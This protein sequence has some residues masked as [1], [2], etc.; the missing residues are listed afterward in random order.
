MWRAN[1]KILAT[2][3]AR[4]CLLLGKVGGRVGNP[5]VKKAPHVMCGALS[6]KRGIGASSYD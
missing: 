3:V 4:D 6:V 2:G 1:D 5:D